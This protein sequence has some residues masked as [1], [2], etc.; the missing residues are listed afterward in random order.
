MYEMLHPELGKIIIKTNSRAR[1]VIARRMSDQILLTVPEGISRKRILETL[2]LMKPKLQKLSTPKKPVFTE[3]TTL[4]AHTF[5]AGIKR[6]AISD[7]FRMTLRNGNLTVFVPQKLDIESPQS[8]SVIKQL[9]EE[10]L[11]H[12]A[13]RILPAKTAQ[14][15]KKFNLS[16][17]QVFIKKLISKWGSCSSDKNI[18]L[19]LYLMLLDE[20]FIDYVIL[21]ELTHTV[22]LNHSAEFWQLLSQFCG[23]DAQGLRSQ[24]KYNLPESCRY[25]FSR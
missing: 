18:N 22:H 2:E 3:S 24:L 7:K 21:H 20:K 9:I 8:Q 16:F 17:R 12:E 25:F 15:A 5:T 14:W 13:K 4:Q 19:S 1:N 23:E 11:R 6:Y 10:G